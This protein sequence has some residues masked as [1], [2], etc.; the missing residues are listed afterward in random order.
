MGRRGPK[1]LSARELQLRGSR[2]ARQRSREEDAALG[3]EPKPLKPPT[4]LPAEAK[5]VWRRFEPK[6]RQTVASLD[7]ALLASFCTTYTQFIEANQILARDGLVI[8]SAK[9][10]G[11]AKNPA[12]TVLN[13]SR[14]ALIRIAGELGLTPAG[15]ERLDLE[16]APRSEE[17]ER[18]GAYMRDRSAMRTRERAC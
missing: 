13:Q 11:L 15:R 9:H 17:Q 12:C 4:W 5:K 14:A 6:V 7:E 3:R 1:A 16:V 2:L 18:F 10:G 8:K